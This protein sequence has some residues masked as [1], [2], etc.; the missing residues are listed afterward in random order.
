[1][2]TLNQRKLFTLASILLSLSAHSAPITQPVSTRITPHFAFTDARLA[3]SIFSAGDPMVIHYSVQGD[4][5][6][7]NTLSGATIYLGYIVQ[8]IF[9]NS[10]SFNRESRAINGANFAVSNLRINPWAYNHHPFYTIETFS[11]LD[12]SGASANLYV[13]GHNDEFYWQ[14]GS[15]TRIRVMRFQLRPNPKSDITPPRIHSLVLDKS[16]YRLGET[17]IVRIT[18]SDDNSGPRPYTAGYIILN[19]GEGIAI[20]DLQAQPFSGGFFSRPWMVPRSLNPGA[21][22]G[23]VTQFMVQDYSGNWGGLVLK[24][25]NDEYYSTS[26]GQPTQM[27]RLAFDIIK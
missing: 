19:T 12:W 20:S 2:N 18:A 6:Q 10:D 5:S 3:T 21:H 7:I 1:M 9:V 17:P 25:L 8:N 22:A 27:R 15:Q 24:S 14:N 16:V 11:V 23:V 26:E 4:T 13:R